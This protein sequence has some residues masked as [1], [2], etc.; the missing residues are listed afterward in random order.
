[1]L[2]TLIIGLILLL[3]SLKSEAQKIPT[4]Q[5]IKEIIKFRDSF[6]LHDFDEELTMKSNSSW[7]KDD[8]DCSEP[9][10]MIEEIEEIA[11]EKP[12]EVYKT[13]YPKYAFFQRRNIIGEEISYDPEKKICLLSVYDKDKKNL[14]NF[15]SIIALLKKNAKKVTESDYLY[16]GNYFRIHEN[17]GSPF[18]K[19]LAGDRYPKGFEHT[20]LVP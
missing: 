16:L 3:S 19:I 10:P 6:V 17:N 14:E 12:K 11:V 8:C 1:M 15:K 13:Q 5:L 9:P 18:I 20:I 4:A 7:I 2:K